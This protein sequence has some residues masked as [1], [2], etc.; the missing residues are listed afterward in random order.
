MM[1]MALL[2]FYVQVIRGDRLDTFYLHQEASQLITVVSDALDHSTK[3][4]HYT[5]FQSKVML[6]C[7]NF[8]S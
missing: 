4:Q 8:I 6:T 1:Y 2:I 7:V 5:S 3:L